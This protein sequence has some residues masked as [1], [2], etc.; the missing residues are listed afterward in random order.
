M[1]E[2][3]H[4][5][6]ELVNADRRNYNNQ[7]KTIKNSRKSVHT[8]RSVL[9]KSLLPDHLWQVLGPEAS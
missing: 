4:N 5:L 8:S 6:V 9:I 7:E 2:K 3:P 1:M